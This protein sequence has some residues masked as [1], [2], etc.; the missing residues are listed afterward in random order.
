MHAQRE[1]AETAASIIITGRRGLIV[2]LRAVLTIIP[3][4]SIGTLQAAVLAVLLGLTLLQ[5]PAIAMATDAAG[6]TGDVVLSAV[7][8]SHVSHHRTTADV[9]DSGED[10]LTAVRSYI[11]RLEYHAS[12]SAAGMQAPSRRHGFRTYFEP[13]GIRIVDREAEGSP[14]LLVLRLQQTGRSNSLAPVAPGE[15]ASDGGR[16]EIRRESLLEWYVNSPAG[17]EQ[18]FTLTERIEGEGPLVLDLSLEG[19]EASLS[20]ETVRIA[21][22]TGRKLTYGLLKAVDAVGAPLP[23]EL[24]VPSA[25]R[26]QLRV[27]DKSAVYPVVIDPLIMADADTLLE[28][29]QTGSLF[30]F[31]VAGAGDV[32]G[33]GYADVII[34]AWRYDS[35]ETDEGAAFIFHGSAIGIADATPATAHT[36]LESDQAGAEMGENVAGAGDVNGDGYDD[37]IVGAWRYDA[38]ETDEGAAFVF[39]GSA[40]GIGASSTPRTRIVGARADAEMGVKVA[41]AGDVN[42]DGYA[43]VIVGAWRYADEGAA[44]IFHGSAAGITNGTPATAQTRLISNQAGAQMGISV[45]GAGD[46]NGDGYAD[47]VVGADRYDAGER[48]EGAA[49][50]FLGSA[51]GIADAT[52]ATA[53]ARLESDQAEA[54]MG[55]S[56]GGAGDVNGDGYDDVIV[57]ARY[58]DAG[59]T[60]EGVVFI[61]QGSAAGIA[62]GSP[63]TAQTRLKGDQA[64]AWMGYSVHGAGDFN[65]DGYAD[66]IVGAGRYDTDASLLGWGRHLLTDASDEG[67][68]FLFLGSASGIADASPASAYAKFESDQLRDYLGTAVSGA[69]DI[70]GDGFDDVVVGAYQYD[71]GQKNEGAAFVILGGDLTASGK[72]GRDLG[73][74]H[75]NCEPLPPEPHHKKRIA[76]ALIVLVGGAGLI[77]LLLRR[78]GRSRK[79]SS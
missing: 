30:G 39:Y 20:G 79:L 34:G 2:G 15:V 55:V 44:F 28:S 17:L 52:P 56:V 62:D 35:G 11:M 75:N 65:G 3:G 74:L 61:F 60:D 24:S 76:A 48:D 49:F 59:K 50:V 71:C 21:T 29:D 8:G 27:D 33:D 72:S 13:T 5:W 23:V 40:G 64:G 9:V 12:E 37:V 47:V 77:V 31:S 6:R 10:W 58:Y 78:R 38:G 46:V 1:Y 73:S 68:A 16:I 45:D 66:V 70:N 22:A 51:S 26:L 57:G 69:G 4:R 54:L 41:G 42:G 63:A 19:A 53:H 43:D 32:N 36:R 25:H 18:G 67:A 7:P 14:Q